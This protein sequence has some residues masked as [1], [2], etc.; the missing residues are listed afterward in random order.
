MVESLLSFLWSW[1]SEDSKIYLFLE[2]LLWGEWEYKFLLILSLISMIIIFFIAYQLFWWRY[3]RLKKSPKHR[4]ERISNYA[5][6]IYKEKY[7][8]FIYLIISGSLVLLFFIRWL[9]IDA[10]DKLVSWL[11]Y[12][13][14]NYP[15]LAILFW[16]KTD[17]IV[18]QYY[19]TWRY[20]LLIVIFFFSVYN[21]I[22][23]YSVWERISNNWTV[24]KYFPLFKNSIKAL[25]II[26]ILLFS[27]MIDGSLSWIVSFFSD[28]SLHDMINWWSTKL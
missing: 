14:E 16:Y 2:S 13:W 20:L 22:M 28:T 11:W 12:D 17:S 7:K 9:W 27:T 19:N 4:G 5:D 24:I 8:L 15:G 26:I 18:Y 1:L 10:L 23:Y 25:V 3:Q 6:Y 21:W